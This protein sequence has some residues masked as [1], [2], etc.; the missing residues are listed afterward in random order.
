MDCV[1][2]LYNINVLHNQKLKKNTND[3]RTLK[4]K[5]LIFSTV[6]K[7]YSK[8]KRRY[9]LINYRYYIVS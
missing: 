9:I 1:V 6:L 7:K 8:L 3:I 2:S 4:H 5:I